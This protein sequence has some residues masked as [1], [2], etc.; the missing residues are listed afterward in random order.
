[1]T[2]EFKPDRFVAMLFSIDEIWLFDS[3][4]R[5]NVDGSPCCWRVML[6]CSNP[7]LPTVSRR[8]SVWA[9]VLFTQLPG[10][11]LGLMVMVYEPSALG[12]NCDKS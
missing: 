6:S 12:V 9:P 11:W 10:C 1:M 8:R 7:Q 3:T 5:V 4:G 2:L